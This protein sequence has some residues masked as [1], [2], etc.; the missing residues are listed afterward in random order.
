[1]SALKGNE[2]GIK[3]MHR[4]VEQAAGEY[5]LREHSE[6]YGGE[7]MAENTIYGRN[8]LQLLRHSWS[9]PRHDWRQQTRRVWRSKF[10]RT[11][12]AGVT[13]NLFP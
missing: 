8:L 4:Q 5:A 10:F 1:V 3:A 13:F 9:D 7:F 2:L 11:Q 6:A 12:T